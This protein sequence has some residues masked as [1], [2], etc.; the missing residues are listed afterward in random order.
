M[1]YYIGDVIKDERK[2]IARTPEKFEASGI[3]VLLNRMVEAVDREKREVRLE[4]G[5]RLPFDVLVLATGAAVTRPPIPGLDLPGVFS[6]KSLPDAM[7]IKKAIG[8]GRVKKA[9]ILGAGFIAMET[10]EAFRTAGI[11]TTLIQ[12]AEL[13]VRRWDPEYSA[14]IK[15]EL[16][17]NGVHCMPL[18]SPLGVEGGTAQGLKVTTDRGDVE[19]DLVLVATGV[20]PNTLLAAQMGIAVGKSGAITV[21]FAQETSGEG[22]YAVG[23]CCESFHRVSRSWTSLPLG[24]IANKQGR[25]AGSNIG[26]VPLLF[27]GV[28]GAQSFKVFDLEVAATGLNEDEAAKSGF[29]PVAG[30]ITGTPTARS[31]STGER[32]HL[33]IV[34]D[35]SSGRLLGAQAVGRKGAVSRINLLSAALWSEVTVDEMAYMDLAYAPPFGGAWDPVHIACQELLK[36]L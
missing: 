35:R 34:A 31:L 24:D 27:P 29:S 5:E 10:A 13:P 36:E 4:N 8:E 9:A 18:T 12:R 22:V 3:H 17:K 23:D 16:Q 14:L 6:L 15:E 20:K 28:V 33:K 11:D 32:L 19:A 30:K 2:L 26:G 25:V 1:P 7:A 21:N